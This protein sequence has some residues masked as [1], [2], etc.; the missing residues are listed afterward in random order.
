MWIGNVDAPKEV[1]PNSN[2]KIK[3]TFYC[4]KFPWTSVTV[5]YKISNEGTYTR[6]RYFG[7]YGILGKFTFDSV[8]SISEDTEFTIEIGLVK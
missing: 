8:Y 5:F 6:T 3:T 4:L 2:F 7:K 1:Y